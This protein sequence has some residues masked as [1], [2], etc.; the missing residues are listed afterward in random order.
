M[1]IDPNHSDREPNF[2]RYKDY[3]LDLFKHPLTEKQVQTSH[4]KTWQRIEK[5]L[6]K[7][8]K[9]RKLIPLSIAA[10]V[11]ILIASS[12]W[13]FYPS[14]SGDSLE[15]LAEQFSI[16]GLQQTQLIFSDEEPIFIDEDESQIR[17]Y[18]NGEMSINNKSN[19]KANAINSLIVP[20]GKRSNIVLEDGSRVWINSG[21]KLIYPA[22]FSDNKR[23]VFLDGEA[24]FE[25][26]EDASKPFIVKTKAMDVSVL[27]TGFNVSAYGN[28]DKISTVLVHGSIAFSTSKKAFFNKSQ[29]LKPGERAILNTVDHT[30]NIKK[31]DIEYYVSWKEGY[32]KFNNN[33]LQHIIGKLEK[34]Y[35]IKISIKDQAILAQTFTGKLDLKQDIEEVI[36]IICSTS[37]LTYSK[38]ERRFIL[39]RK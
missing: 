18:S 33:K 38:Y 10:S 6:N 37:A 9:H 16:D 2:G 7:S 39:D 20:Y 11:C 21:S 22:V 30:V 19:E 26:H 1:A 32:M 12:I 13:I 35:D 23:E 15:A 27:G 14:Y 8:N 25:I 24:Y 29:L 36:N 5:T 34:Y 17:Y 31:V 4:D 3:F 28:D